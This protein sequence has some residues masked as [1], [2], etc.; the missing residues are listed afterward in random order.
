MEQKLFIIWLYCSDGFKFLEDI[1][2][3]S[4]NWKSFTII[5]HHFVFKAACPLIVFIFA[6]VGAKGENKIDLNAST[7][8][9]LVRTMPTKCM[10]F[11][12][13]ENATDDPISILVSLLGFH[14]NSKKKKKRFYP[15]CKT[16]R[17]VTTDEPS[18]WKTITRFWP[19]VSDGLP[20]Q[21]WFMTLQY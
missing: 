7:S 11:C 1:P 8:F 18:G 9:L 12:L 15:T 17:F 20:V 4:I 16:K 3:K 14:S 21:T 2:W 10:A 5:N 6:W 13:G 19:Y